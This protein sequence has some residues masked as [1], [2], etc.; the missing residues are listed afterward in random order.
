LRVCKGSGFG[1]DKWQV[2]EALT[3]TVIPAELFEN[4]R[5]LA[6]HGIPLRHSKILHHYDT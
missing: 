1:W 4:F 6:N 5:S 3:G 2:K